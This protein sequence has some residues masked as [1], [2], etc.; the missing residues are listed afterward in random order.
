MYVYNLPIII[1]ASLDHDN[2]NPSSVVEQ[3]NAT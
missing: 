3:I 1:I 2:F